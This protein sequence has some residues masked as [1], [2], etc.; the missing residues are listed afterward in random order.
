MTAG[1][2]EMH[3]G[4]D[5]HNGGFRNIG[6]PSYVKSYGHTEAVQVLVSEDPDGPYWGWLRFA[7]EANGRAWR[8]ADEAPVMIQRHEGVFSMQFTYGP[9]AEVKAG[10]GRIVHLKITEQEP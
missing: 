1:T 10:K 7:S 5:E 6:H 4:R 3:A 2:W 8:P 9:E